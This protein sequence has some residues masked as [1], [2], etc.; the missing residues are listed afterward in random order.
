MTTNSA[1]HPKA[2]RWVIALSSSRRLASSAGSLTGSFL[3]PICA[4][5]WGIGIKSSS[6]WPSPRNGS[7]TSPRRAT[8]IE[9]I[10]PIR[11]R[12]I[13]ELRRPHPTLMVIPILLILLSLA[14]SFALGF[15]T[16]RLLGRRLVKEVT[17][18]DAVNLG[19]LSSAAGT[20][21]G[22]LWAEVTGFDRFALAPD[23]VRDAWMYSGRS[24]ILELAQPVFSGALCAVVVILIARYSPRWVARLGI[25]T[26][27]AGLLI[28]FAD[29]L[30][31]PAIFGPVVS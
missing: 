31:W 24:F 17:L 11:R 4:A 26:P 2:L 3:P 12:L 30:L 6:A 1:M 7:A 16:V 8:A 15:L 5:S 14:A 28:S 22:F 21:A 18:G 19:A 27:L 13:R 25:V 20:A 9:V 23:R 29:F 10:D